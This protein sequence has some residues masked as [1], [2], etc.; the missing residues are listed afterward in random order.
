[1]ES[2]EGYLRGIILDE[3]HGWRERAFQEE[4]GWGVNDQC[5]TSMGELTGTSE[6]LP[7]TK[8]ITGNGTVLSL[9]KQIEDM[10]DGSGISAEKKNPTKTPVRRFAIVVPLMSTA[11]QDYTPS[12]PSS[13]PLQPR[14]QPS[15]TQRV[16]KTWEE[17]PMRKE[18]E[19]ESEIIMDMTRV[20]KGSVKVHHPSLCVKVKIQQSENVKPE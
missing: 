11:K 10:Q 17:K 20:T 6:K 1:V 16:G 15:K 14:R 5:K 2:Y 7:L 8:L 4:W 9:I 13:P 12:P 19:R 18:Q 3:H